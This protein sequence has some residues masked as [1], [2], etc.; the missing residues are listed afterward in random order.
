MD[1]PLRYFHIICTD[2]TKVRY[3]GRFQCRSRTEAYKLLRTKVERKN[4]RGLKYSITEI[5]IE[6]LR[7]IVDAIINEKA[8]PQ[9]DIIKRPV[10]ITPKDTKQKYASVSD[11]R[12]DPKKPTMG[13][14][15]RRLGDL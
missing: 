15:K 2:G 11:W 6:I 9:G 5:P 3:E 13:N 10:Y 7:E 14:V 8:L 4:L 12:R 1:S